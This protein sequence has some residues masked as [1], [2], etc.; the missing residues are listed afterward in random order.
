MGG[1]FYRLLFLDG[2]LLDVIRRRPPRVTGDGRSTVEELIAAENARRVDR[3]HQAL[4]WP[5]RI[6]LEC[7]LTLQAQDLTLS[8]V[9][10]EGQTVPVKTVI[11]QNTIGDNE[12][13]RGGIAA[14]LIEPA[15]RAR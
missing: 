6:D 7:I 3:R 8:S 11:S 12:T 2:E 9:L 4:L 5:L 14:G 10:A 1:E 13:V 15:R